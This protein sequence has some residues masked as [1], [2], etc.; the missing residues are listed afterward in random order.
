MAA[1]D[2]AAEFGRTSVSR[3]LGE[4]QGVAAAAD[5]EPVLAITFAGKGVGPSA[6]Q[7]PGPDAALFATAISEFP[8]E[9]LAAV[10]DVAQAK[11]GGHI[12]DE[13]FVDEFV[14][15][16][17]DAFTFLANL[18]GARED[19]F[20]FADDVVAVTIDFGCIEPRFTVFEAHELAV[21]GAAKAIEVLVS[22]TFHGFFFIALADQAVGVVLVAHELAVAALPAGIVDKAVFVCFGS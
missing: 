4:I 14:T 15:V 22:A 2:A 17:V 8:F 13:P 10:A 9:G 16:V 18:D 1:D 3:K 6:D 20:A 11:L 21:A 19:V 12:I 7:F 5:V